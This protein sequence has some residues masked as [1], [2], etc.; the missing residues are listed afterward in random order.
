MWM[1]HNPHQLMNPGSHNDSGRRYERVTVDISV[2]I[3][4]DSVVKLGR[5]NDLSCTGMSVYAPAEYALGE[6]VHT[7]FTLPSSRMKLEIAAVIKNR[8]GFRYGLE[9]QELNSHQ[10]AEI[11]RVT[12]ILALTQT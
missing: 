11:T 6:I 9:F 3:I 5:A 7:E 8:I 1:C 2:R 4:R 12:G 10:K